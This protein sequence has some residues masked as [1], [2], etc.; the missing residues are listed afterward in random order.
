MYYSKIKRFA[1]CLLY[2][3]NVS[4]VASKKFFVSKIF[5]MIT[6]TATPF[7]LLVL[8][9]NAIN[10]LF[11][12]TANLRSILMLIGLY[13]TV[14]LLNSILEKADEFTNYRYNDCINL[15]L[16]NLM[17][18]KLSSIDLEFFDSSEKMNQM[19]NSRRLLASLQHT[20]WIFFSMIQSFVKLIVAS[21]L[22]SSLNIWLFLIIIIINIPVFV[23]KRKVEEVEFDYGR[24][25]IKNFRKMSYFKELFFNSSINE[26]RLYNLKGFF[27][28]KYSKEWREWFSGKKKLRRKTFVSA[29]A[30]SF[31]S[32]IG[33]IIT[34]ALAVQRLVARRIGV[35]DAQY[36]ISIT[37]SLQSEM[38]NVI[39]FTFSF[40]IRSK[41]IMIVRD[42]IEMKSTM[43]MRGINKISGFSDIVFENVSFK[44]PNSDKY[45][46]K[47]CSFRINSHERIGLVGLNGAGKT[48]I[49]KLLLRFYD[50]IDGR[51]L[52]DGQDLKDIDIKSLRIL[53]S[54]L[55]QDFTR[56]SLS[57]R[58][59]IV[60]SDM[61]K[62]AET[63][64]ILQACKKSGVYDFMSIWENGLDTNLT[65]MFDPAGQELSLGQWQKVALARTY[66]RDTDVLLLDEPSASLDPE[67]EHVIFENIYKL[68]IDKCVLLISHRLSNITL[69]DR[70]LVIEDGAIK[71][72]GAHYDLMKLNGQYAYLFKLQSDKY[73]KD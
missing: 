67:A 27:I 33:F 38:D 63:D 42:F 31:V 2:S 40:Y 59:N 34:L 18:E 61:D 12:G 29:F 14:Y 11:D 51:I 17:T 41:E 25:S 52:I 47:N 50:P 66:F 20:V 10:L 73:E 37:D 5:L 39:D 7:V 46:L 8:W 15:Y 22:L 28:Q 6:L 30:T 69:A 65:R 3:F 56:Y 24:Y 4:F 48:T 60:L 72:S 49:V 43:D 13:M 55:F 36:Y 21:I 71:E 68:A 70:I 54:V 35:G 1:E 19:T 45:V 16:D 32:S 64:L 26:I 53:Y 23:V 9:R 58:E 57:L 62:S 44:Y